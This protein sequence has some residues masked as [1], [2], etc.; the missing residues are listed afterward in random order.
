MVPI[1]NAKH[2]YYEMFLDL[3]GQQKQIITWD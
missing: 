1:E 3:L 2:Q